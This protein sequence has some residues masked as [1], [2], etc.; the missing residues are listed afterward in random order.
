MNSPSTI[1]NII[2][3]GKGAPDATFKGGINY[4][5]QSGHVVSL[6]GRSLSNGHYYLANRKGL[7]PGYPAP[8]TQAIVFTESILDATTINK[9]TDYQALALYGTHITSN[10]HMHV[11]RH[12]AVSM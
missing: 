10:A 7:Y 4:K 12:N 1:T 3:S 5:D 9:Y 2:K 11:V 6:Y 8:G